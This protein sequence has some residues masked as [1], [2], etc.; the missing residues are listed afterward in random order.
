M[1]KNF[2]NQQEQV[3][4]LKTYYGSSLD[5]VEVTVPLTEIEMIDI[6]GQ[7]CNEYDRGCYLCRLW[8]QWQHNYQKVTVTLSRNQ[9]VE[10]L[11]FDINE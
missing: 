3:K 6:F 10:G 5:W 11:G 7:C 8:D 1:S 2:K 4:N 9:I